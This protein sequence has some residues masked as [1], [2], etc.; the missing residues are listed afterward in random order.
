M[1]W[2]LILVGSFW[3]W[4]ILAVEFCVVLWCLEFERFGWATLTL[5]ATVLGLHLLG[6]ANV[7]SWIWGHPW[8]FAGLIGCYFVAGT[9]WG[10]VK[11]WFFVRDVRDRYEDEKKIW[12]SVKRL[13]QDVESLRSRLEKVKKA[14][15]DSEY[16]SK[17]Q[18]EVTAYEQAVKSGGGLTDALKPFWKA[19]VDEYTWYDHLDRRVHLTKPEPSEYK[20]RILGW[21]SL[22]PCSF[23][24]TMLND[25]IKRLF[26]EIYRCVSRLLVAISNSAWR[27]QEDDFVSS[28]EKPS[29]SAVE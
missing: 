4:F 7:F 5:I 11:W 20:S 18:R 1:L 22:W 2:E 10:I 6:N 9:I 3:F 17:L 27:R 26:K 8:Q 15:A 23:I 19:H 28:K 25:P 12:C 29:E 21:M 14:D 13:K 24:W 16:A